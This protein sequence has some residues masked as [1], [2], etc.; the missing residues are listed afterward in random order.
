MYKKITKQNKNANLYQKIQTA[1]EVGTLKT[2]KADKDDAS[3]T[4][5]IHTKIASYLVQWDV[6]HATN[7]TI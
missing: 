1:V 5:R 4:K 6:A 2:Y 3:Q 7:S